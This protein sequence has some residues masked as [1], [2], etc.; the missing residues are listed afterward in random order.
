[1][2]KPFV[3]TWNTQWVSQDNG[4]QGSATLTVT[5]SSLSQS[6]ELVLNG[7]W[8]APD[9][10]PGT[11]HGKLS[12]NTWHGEWW[13]SPTQRGEFTFTL[14][15]DDKFEGTYNDA[16]RPGL[17]SEIWNGTLIRNHVPV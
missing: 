1:M 10:R 17:K 3:G 14:Q 5:E 9:M 13:L 16:N 8:D 11:V 4:V 7:F 2:A 6:S 12:G 15:G